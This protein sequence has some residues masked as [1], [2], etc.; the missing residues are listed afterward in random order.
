MLA[1]GA[2]CSLGVAAG[3]A[4]GQLC[5]N[6]RRE[7][8]PVV[9]GA[10]MMLSPL[11]LLALINMP[12][13]NANV[14]SHICMRVATTSILCRLHYI[15]CSECANSYIDVYCTYSLKHSYTVL[16]PHYI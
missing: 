3:G 2:G 8:L 12:L 9:M 13:E 5:Y 16:N 14:S 4:G 10:A 1:F 6:T 11:P 15:K 7:L